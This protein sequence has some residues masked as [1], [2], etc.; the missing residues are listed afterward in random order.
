MWRLKTITPLYIL[1]FEPRPLKF[2]PWRSRNMAKKRNFSDVEIETLISK[3]I[4]SRNHTLIIPSMKCISLNALRKPAVNKINYVLW[5]HTLIIP[6][7]KCISP[8][9]LRKPA[10]NEVNYVSR[11]HTLI[12]PSTKC[13]LAN[14]LRKPAVNEVNYVSRNHTLIIPSTKCISSNALREPA[15]DKINYVSRNH[16]ADSRNALDERHFVDRIIPVWFCDT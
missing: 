10:V 6:S 8:N 11:N 16:S 1:G 9:A 5:D 4:V 2:T 15:V 14:A 12:I 7:M 3:W 13:I